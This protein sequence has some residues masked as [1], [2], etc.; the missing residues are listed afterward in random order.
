M[1][2]SLGLQADNGENA[3]DRDKFAAYMAGLDAVT[4]E[5]HRNPGQDLAHAGALPLESVFADIITM[6]AEHDGEHRPVEHRLGV[7]TRRWIWSSI[8]GSAP[9]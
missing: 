8:I 3:D 2:W 4:L 1:L 6:I 9:Q 7:P 5:E